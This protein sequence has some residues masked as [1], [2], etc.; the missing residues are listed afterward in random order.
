MLLKERLGLAKRLYV[1]HIPAIVAGLFIGAEA[2]LSL[3]LLFCCLI[4]LLTAVTATLFATLVRPERR[5]E[6]IDF[7]IKVSVVNA[8][9]LTVGFEIDGHKGLI[10][11]AAGVAIALVVT[12]AASAGFAW[13]WNRAAA[14]VL[15]RYRQF[16]DAVHCGHCGYNLTGNT[17]GRCPECGTEIPDKPPT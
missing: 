5:G 6:H 15:P 13:M 2:S 11:C 3:W 17:S 14:R 8:L 10:E 12:G 1:L 9:A 16:V 4:L 7:V